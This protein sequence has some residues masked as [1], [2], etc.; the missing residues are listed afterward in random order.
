MDNQLPFREGSPN[1]P[2]EGAAP[3]A[4]PD[5]APTA[6]ARD[7]P[8]DSGLNQSISDLLAVLPGVPTNTDVGLVE[9]DRVLQ[10]NG[11]RCLTHCPDDCGAPIPPPDYDWVVNNQPPS[12]PEIYFR[13]PAAPGTPPRLLEVQVERLSEQIAD[14]TRDTTNNARRVQELER[15]R[16]SITA[17]IIHQTVDFESRLL[18]LTARVETAVRE[19]QRRAPGPVHITL[20]PPPPLPL[21][22]SHRRRAPR[23]SNQRSPQPRSRYAARG[24]VT[25]PRRQAPESPRRRPRSPRVQQNRPRGGNRWSNWEPIDVV[26]PIRRPRESSPQTSQVPRRRNPNISPIRAPRYDSLA[27]NIRRTRMPMGMTT[28]AASFA[29]NYAQN[30]SR[31]N[32]GPSSPCPSLESVP[33]FE[34]SQQRPPA[35]GAASN[36]NPERPTLLAQSVRIIRLDLRLLFLRALIALRIQYRANV[37][38]EVFETSILSRGTFESAEE[39]QGAFQLVFH[40]TASVYF[41][42]LLLLGEEELDQML[43]D[44]LRD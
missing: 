6:V 40:Q 17:E 9:P 34:E 2:Q 14:L 13:R 27:R 19:Q 11:V 36:P 16:E 39:V 4:P 3:D 20:R 7:E 38:W 5:E 22:P 21:S 12:P 18:Q 10:P 30:D 24:Q 33:G 25:S 41:P 32:S 28:S 23:A 26:Q 42:R 44:A 8:H 29:E 37:T 1:E 31:R 15:S 43:F 35:D